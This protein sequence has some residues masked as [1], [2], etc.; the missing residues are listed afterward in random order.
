MFSNGVSIFSLELFS[1]FP[2]GLVFGWVGLFFFVFLFFFFWFLLYIHLAQ[3][4]VD[5]RD[6]AKFYHFCPSSDPPVPWRMPPGE[7]N[8][9]GKIGSYPIHMAVLGV[10]YSRGGLRMVRL[11]CIMPQ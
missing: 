7:L 5:R 11:S 8:L 1:W 2:S 6:V 9:E 4:L 3:D 10:G